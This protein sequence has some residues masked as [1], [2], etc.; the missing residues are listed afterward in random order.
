M[1]TRQ[2]PVSASRKRPS[3][4]MGQRPG[5]AGG[6]VCLMSHQ[7]GFSIEPVNRMDVSSKRYGCAPPIGP[8]L[9]GTSMLRLKI[10]QKRLFKVL[11]RTLMKKER[12]CWERLELWQLSVEQI[13]FWPGSQVMISI[14]MLQRKTRSFHLHCVSLPKDL[15]SPKLDFAP[16][17]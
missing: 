1:S 7:A 13:R 3:T 9:H 11:L 2:R 17:D 6:M 4:A 16:D 5:S 14:I 10:A 8:K 12:T 15:S